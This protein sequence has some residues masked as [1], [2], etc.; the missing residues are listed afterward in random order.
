M[1]KRMSKGDGSVYRMK[2]GRWR[3]AYKGKTRT[4]QTEQDAKKALRKLRV[5][6]ESSAFD[7]PVIDK[8]DYT[9]KELAERFLAMKRLSIK[10]NSYDRL[11]STV[12]CQI[13]PR[14]GTAKIKKLS[15]AIINDEL[16]AP[17][18]TDKLSYS[19]VKKAYDALNAMLRYAV[20]KDIILKSPM[21]TVGMP[22]KI[23]FESDGDE[24][25]FFLSP[26]D[27]IAFVKAARST[28]SN[29]KPRFSNADAYILDLYTGLRMGELLALKWTNVDMKTKRLTVKETLVQEKDRDKDSNTFGKRISKVSPRTKN[30]KQRT[31]PIGTK[32]L[33]ALMNLQ[34][35]QR[36]DR[37]T[38]PFVVSASDGGFVTPTNIIKGLK[39]ICHVAGIYLPDNTG[40]HMLRHTFAS[41]LFAKGVSVRIISELLGHS[42][43]QIT[44]NIYI[45]LLNEQNV[46]AISELDTIE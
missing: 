32:A 39:S 43:V 7:E 20:D 44:M 28:Y 45:H 26:E 18:L 22:Q 27:R 4:V 3:A 24:E 9:V 15:D 12:N 38:S 10:P 25:V 30:S 41:M 35:R 16:L 34:A 46:Q 17:M 6:V 8:T 23:L 2:N 40:M 33:E 5:D 13:M 36:R 19:S 42:S 31:I 14:I 11:E 21:R 1:A 37:I 29:G